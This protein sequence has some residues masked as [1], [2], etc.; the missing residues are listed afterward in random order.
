[1]SPF[2]NHMPNKFDSNIGITTSRGGDL[3]LR[4][5]D[6][7]IR[8]LTQEAKIGGNTS[9]ANSIAVREPS[10]HWNGS[11]A[12]FSMVVGDAA[13]TTWQ[14]YEVSGLGKG[15]TAS[16]CKVRG[17]S[18]YNNVSPIYAADDRVLF[19]SDAPRA[20]TATNAAAHLYPQL[21][22]YESTPTITGLWSVNPDGSALTILSHTPSGAFSPSIDSFGRVIFTRWDHL[23]QDQQAVSYDAYN[24]A[25]EA[26]G[27]ARLA[28]A[29]VFPEP[30]LSNSTSKFGPVPSHDFNLFT[31]WQ[32]NQDGTDELTLNHIGRH[33]WRGTDLRR[34]FTSDPSLEDFT[35]SAFAANKTIVRKDGGLFHIKEDPRNPG[36]FY[37]TYAREFGSMTASQLMR[38]TGAPTLNAEEMVFTPITP[39]DGEASFPAGRFRDPLPLSTGG[40]VAVHTPLTS[41][42]VTASSRPDF[43]LRLLNVDAAGQA[44]LGELLTGSGFTKAGKLLWELEP[45]EV[46]ARNR[47]TRAA[48]ALEAPERTIFTAEGVDEAALRSWLRTNNLALI[49][50]R[51]QTSRDRAD[52]QQ[53][54]NLQVPG[55]VK[56]VGDGG[57]V[58]D[59]AHFQIVQ[60]EQIR[61]YAAF[62]NS[63]AGR[64]VIGQFS[65]V[66]KNPTTAG[67]AGSVKIAADGSTAAFVP[68]RRAL[69]WQ[70]T[71]VDGTPVVRERVWVTMQP[72]EVRTCAGCHGENTRNQAGQPVSTNP[73]EALRE[74]LRHWK[75]LPK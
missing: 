68:A 6:G 1:M 74:L 55:G 65:K 72:G 66:D 43:R 12:L 67:P 2:A 58:Y 5:P 56:T 49:I 13:S 69:S 15:Q 47:P 32:I 3:M 62:N 35:V 59:I 19:T 4:Y 27:A 57:R 26:A 16:I 40:L 70:T 39:G 41:G 21:D 44:S 24:L 9:G 75:T 30:F 20:Y 18:P 37:S 34:S 71:D 29:E 23:K 45:V 22:E 17:Q 52:K 64:R 14:I 42:L 11:K 60:G 25:S 53:P 8:N 61:G 7:S 33:E 10:V 31:P 38:F 46:V 48:P 28:R 63:T 36:I 73:P 54:F 50:S 51:N